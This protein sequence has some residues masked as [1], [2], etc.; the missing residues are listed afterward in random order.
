MNLTNLYTSLQQTIPEMTVAFFGMLVFTL[1]FALPRMEKKFLYYI[2]VLGFLLAFMFTVL[3]G[4][5]NT[6]VYSGG[7]TIDIFALFFKVLFYMIGIVVLLS[8]IEY[9]KIHEVD[10]GEYPALVIF[11]VLGML[12]MASASDFIMFFVGLELSSLSSYVLT[13]FTTRKDKKTTEA[14]V[15]YFLLGAFSSALM[16]Y[17]MSL[18]YGV[19]GEI[20][21]TKIVQVLA[22]GKTNY[23]MSVAGMML[24]VGFSFKIA[25]VPMHMYVPDVYEGAPTPVSGF[26]SVGPKAAALAVMLR[27]FLSVLG[28]QKVEWTL[29]LAVMAAVSMTL[30]NFLALREENVK[31]LLA[32][33]GIANTGYVLVGFVAAG[34]SSEVGF[35]SVMLFFMFYAMAK[36]GAFSILALV[37]RDKSVGDTLDEIKGLS[38][39]SPWAAAMFAIFV[40]SLAGIPPTTGFLAKFWIVSAAMG[41]NHM[42]WLAWI[43]VINAVISAYYYLKLIVAV[44]FQPVEEGNEL[45]VV[46]S[47]SLKVAITLMAILTIYFGL[48]PGVF[49]DM[50]HHSFKILL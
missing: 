38:L 43:T 15:K 19:T 35:T 3:Q 18:V 1:D 6:V 39:V 12:V 42:T 24:L 32:Y 36:I 21:F 10:R 20:A 40:F 16:L 48:R 26:I 4:N 50:A 22:A 29:I 13:G 28:T 30:G 25:A 47:A 45:S 31:R 17:G 49:F 23:I 7:F 34:Y 33:S 27:M 11:A 46:S 14:A 41:T 2:G 8:S 5:S 44:Y 37:C 9:N